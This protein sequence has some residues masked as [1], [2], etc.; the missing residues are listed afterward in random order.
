M[1]FK[2]CLH[3]LL[4][5]YYVAVFGIS[6][7]GA[8][9]TLLNPTY[10]AREVLY[11]LQDAG[12]TSLIVG[13]HTLEAF[14]T[15]QKEHPE[16]SAHTKK[17]YVFGEDTAAA[18]KYHFESF[19]SLYTAAPTPPSVSM[20]PSNDVVILPYSRYVFLYSYLALQ[21]TETTFTVARRVCLKE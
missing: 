9:A 3:S 12:A 8:T 17:V 16:V 7:T 4:L 2:C 13:T 21:L 18:H 10:S 11:Q 6:M 19:S 14:V 15:C 20:D 1:L 5:E